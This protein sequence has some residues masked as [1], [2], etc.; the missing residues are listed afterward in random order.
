MYKSGLIFGAGMF[1]L[2]LLASTTV[3]PCFAICIA[4]G[5]GLAAGYV[6][7]V[8]D[9]PPS[10]PEA[11]RKG[12]V[13]GAITG[14]MA[15]LANIIGALVSGFLYQSN[16]NVYVS[17]CPGSQLP[18]PA[19]FWVVELGLGACVALVNVG[20]T[21]GLGIAGSAI[22]FSTAGKKGTSAHPPAGIIS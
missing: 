7:G 1:V 13:A 5:L 8:F 3:S 17:M 12:A 9:H 21:T 2:V 10:S 18:D 14:I 11:T 19:T 20:L 6:A 22:W 15:I 16:Q 4:I